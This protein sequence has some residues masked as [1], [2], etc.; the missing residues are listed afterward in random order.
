M[1]HIRAVGLF[2]ANELEALDEHLHGVEA[3]LTA[4]AADDPARRSLGYA[5]ILRASSALFRGDVARC[6]EL[7]RQGLATLPADD[8]SGRIAASVHVA[9]A[10]LLTGD[11]GPGAGRLL[12]QAAEAARRSGELTNQFYALVSLAAFRRRQGLLD[13]AAGHYREAAQL[14]PDEQGILAL[15]NG[16]NYFFGLGDLLAE[17]HDPAPRI[18]W[19]GGG[20]WCRSSGWPRGRASSRATRPSPR[21]SRPAA[22]TPPPRRPWRSSRRPAGAGSRSGCSRAE[23]AA[24]H[25]AL[26]RGDLATAAAWAE[27][28]GITANDE[29]DYPREREQLTFCRVRL[30]QGRQRPTGPALHEALGML[31]RLLAAAESCERLDS[32]IEL[33]VLRALTFEAQGRRGDGLR[34]LERA[35]RLAEPGG[36]VRVFVAEGA[37][38]A[39][40][41]SGMKDAGARMKPYIARLVAACSAEAMV[42]GPNLQ[43]ASLTLRPSPEP[44]TRRELDVL[45]L[46]ALGYSNQAIA[47]ELVLAVGTVKRHI[48]N[49]FGK[50]QVESRLQAVARARDLDLL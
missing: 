46:L 6:V 42:A 22:T 20:R 35:L 30:A 19:P 4:A 29:P 3:Q 21:C 34:S 12:S 2:F 5:T 36:Y 49:L 50:L 26:R 14:L 41:L 44:L 38:V 17:R 8:S 23:A 15:P 24:A 1:H 37:A 43:P 31:A 16:A 10:Y 25:L 13:E 28:S 40:L 33:L 27:R 47:R 18:C 7:A 48:N 32:V 39:T 9:E 11:V 45:R